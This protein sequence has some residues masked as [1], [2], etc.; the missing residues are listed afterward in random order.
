MFSLK[1]MESPY[2][3]P[4]ELQNIFSQIFHS[5]Q[6]VKAVTESA[7]CICFFSDRMEIKNTALVLCLPFPLRKC[8]SNVSVIYGLFSRH[9]HQ[10]TDFMCI[11]TSPFCT[12]YLCAISCWRI[13]LGYR[14]TC[15]LQLVCDTNVGA[16]QWKINHIYAYMDLKHTPRKYVKDFMSHCTLKCV[17]IKFTIWLYAMHSH[18]ILTIA[19]TEQQ[20]EENLNEQVS[21]I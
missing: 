5:L 7:D 17:R 4:P 8:L 13:S 10:R 12:V 1:Y 2:G 3:P 21:W 15:W 11:Y 6:S 18:C 20:I 9:T 19:I 16:L 14:W